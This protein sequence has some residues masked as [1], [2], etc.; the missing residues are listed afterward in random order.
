MITIS[1]LDQR[2]STWGLTFYLPEIS[3]LKKIDFL[4]CLYAW[5]CLS[6]I[7]IEFSLFCFFHIIEKT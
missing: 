1:G 6:V 2:F 5:V 7:T 4:A 3:Y